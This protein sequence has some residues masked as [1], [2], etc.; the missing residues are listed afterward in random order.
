MGSMTHR[1][2]EELRAG[3]PIV[4]AAPAD[5]GTVVLVTCRPELGQRVILERAELS[6]EVGLV[7]DN[8]L[9]RG[10]RHTDDGA[11]EPARQ[12]TL[13]SSRVIELIAGPD[14]QRWALAGDQLY[15]DFDLSEANLPAG[16][17]LA[18]GSAVVEVSPAPHPGCAKFVARFGSD[19]ARF[20]VSPD[21]MARR[22]RGVN[23]TVV[24]GGWVATGDPV[25]RL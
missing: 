7:G 13:M 1:T 21:G 4:E 23:A 15:V 14:R 17:R 5:T 18:V 11:A 3:L 22:L 10:S 16:T 19:A 25:S 6:P 9:T 20:V 24:R 8:W 12:L 2:L